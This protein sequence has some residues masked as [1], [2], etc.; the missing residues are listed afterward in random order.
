M[1]PIKDLDLLIASGDQMVGFFQ[2]FERLPRIL[3]VIRSAQEMPAELKKEIKDRQDELRGLEDKVTD[4]ICELDRIKESYRLSQST[5]NALDAKFESETLRVK[6]LMDAEV[7]EARQAATEKMQRS[8][9]DMNKE[10]DLHKETIK[11]SEEKLIESIDF[12]KRQIDV[13]KVKEDE[14]RALADEAMATL[15][16]IKKSFE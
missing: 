6:A 16:K 12:H 9:K 4:Q 10:L 5:L 15:E 14:A 2:A 8:L 13:Y 3:Q 1:E 11:E 7:H